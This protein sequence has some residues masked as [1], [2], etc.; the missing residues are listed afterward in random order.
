MSTT[1]FS[2]QALSSNHIRVLEL[3]PAQKGETLVCNLRT[4][5][6]QEIP[7]EAISYVWGKPTKDVT[8]LCDGQILSITTNLSEALA[9]FRLKGEPRR[10]WADG[11][12]I[13][14]DDDTEREAQVRLMGQIYST[15]ERVLGWLG[16]DA[17]NGRLIKDIIYR[18][19]YRPD[20]SI[21]YVQETLR[22]PQTPDDNFVAE[23]NAIKDFFDRPFFHRVWIIQELGLGKQAVLWFGSHS[24]DW[25]EISRFVFILDNKAAF[26]VN[27]FRL[28]SWIVN[29]TY[30]IWQHFNGRPRYSFEEILHWARV[31]QSTDQRDRI[32]AMLGHPSATVDGSLVVQPNY[33][34]SY[35]PP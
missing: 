1:A 22:L 29:H 4:Q 32:F 3:Q 13:N 10:L 12:C 19:N 20:E 11:I 23:W 15:A 14:Q 33:A 6:L 18:F 5:G 30:L 7:Y 34:S 9:A 28:R 8:I 2:Y 27:H 24:I 31:H 16:P 35:T 21:Q 26:L 25:S 17:G